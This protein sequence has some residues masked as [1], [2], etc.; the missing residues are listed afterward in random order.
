[1]RWFH[2]NE[3]QKQIKEDRPAYLAKPRVQKAQQHPDQLIYI[4]NAFEKD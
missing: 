1:M 2:G 4:S 3:L